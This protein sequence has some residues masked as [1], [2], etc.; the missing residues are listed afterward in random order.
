M[1]RTRAF[2]LVELLVVIGI[3]AVLISLLLPAMNRAR[4]A[5]LT[6]NCASNQRQI[7]LAVTFY[8][9]EYGNWWP[10]AGGISV[11]PPVDVNGQVYNPSGNVSIG[12]FDVPLLGKYLHPNT[13]G[14]LG[15]FPYSTP[16][17]MV[18]HCPAA[19]SSRGTVANKTDYRQT[20]IGFNNYF[21]CQI[22]SDKKGPTKLSAIGS[23]SRA[24]ILADCETMN[25]SGLMIPGDKWNIPTTLRYGAMTDDKNAPVVNSSK[26]R[27]QGFNS[28]RH[29]VC[30][31]GFADGH[32][33]GIRDVVT[34]IEQ[35]DILIQVRSK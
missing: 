16:S 7:M 1:K 20:G 22:W 33:E 13:K 31:V 5:A 35:R 23:A 10:S 34:A 28:Y 29:G 17:S 11:S 14:L 27:W 19:A 32:V 2:T 12:W 9:N 26:Y 6:V 30:N 24:V 3:I 15:Q 4:K 8:H 18:M 25:G 21:D